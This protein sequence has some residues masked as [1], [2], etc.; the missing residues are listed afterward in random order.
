MGN[1]K[2]EKL[3]IK[4][5][6]LLL[7]P[8]PFVVNQEAF[9]RKEKQEKNSNNDVQDFT[10]LAQ[11]SASMTDDL[12]LNYYLKSVATYRDLSIVVIETKQR[13]NAKKEVQIWEYGLP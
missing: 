8:E 3:G 2:N 12:D 5:L 1:N 11:D 6:Q 7:N 10:Q 13:Q 9:S 4:G